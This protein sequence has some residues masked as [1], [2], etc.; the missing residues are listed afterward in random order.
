[1]L[2]PVNLKLKCFQI[3]LLYLLVLYPAVW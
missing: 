1:M 2:E 3:T